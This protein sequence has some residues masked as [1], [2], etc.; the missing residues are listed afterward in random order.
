M[1]EHFCQELSRFIQG[2][3]VN[4]DQILSTTEMEEVETRMDI[5]GKNSTRSCSSNIYLRRMGK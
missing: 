3:S 5:Q 2:Q 1:D 4:Q